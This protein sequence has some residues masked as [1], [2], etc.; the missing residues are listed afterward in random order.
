METTVIRPLLIRFLRFRVWLFEALRPGELQVTLIWAGVIGFL[1]AI[2]SVFFRHCLSGVQ[3][4]LIHHSNDLVQVSMNLSWWERLLLPT[5]GGVLAGF[6]LQLGTRLFP[7]QS[8][9][10]YMEAITLGDGIIRFRSTVIKSISSLFTIAS[11]GSIGREGPMVQLSSMIASLIGRKGKLTKPRLRLLVA[12]GAAAGIASAYNAPIAGALFVAEIIMG[13]I[14]MESFGPLIFSSVIATVTVRHILGGKP[15]YQIPPFELVSNWELIPYAFLGIITG[16]MAPGFLWLLQRS[17]TI[18]SRWIV[19][20]PFKLGLGGAIVGLISTVQPEVYGNGYS[21]VDSILHESWP[22]TLLILLLAAKVLATSVTAGSGAAGGV[23][24]PTLFVGAAIGF[25]WGVP[26]HHFWPSVM[27]SPNAYALVGMGCFL[28]GTTHA[29]LM[30]ILMIFEMTLDYAIVPPL[31]LA[32]VTAFYTSQSLRSGSIYAESLARKKEETP[33]SLPEKTVGELMK[34]EPPYVRDIARFWE[35]AQ[36]LAQYRYNYIYVVDEKD[37]FCGAISLHD[38]KE[39]LN[40][41]ELAHLII[42]LDLMRF[43]FPTLTPEMSLHEA[44]DCFLKHDGERLPVLNGDGHLLG[45]ISKTDLLLS[46][47]H[48]RSAAAASTSQATI[49]S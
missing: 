28:A 5:V 47:A 38:I 46:L 14:A 25:L 9:T 39:H 12:C 1:G 19:S 49:P 36:V 45:T 33:E 29:P 40:H 43:D 35:I 17:E 26:V 15:V 4:L 6:V 20:L 21:V 24:T 32:C 44:L 3:W 8:S 7:G 2:I 48:V 13:S 22:W 30:S 42:A 10:D 11:G 27:A 16:I 37:R 34:P 23:F 18:F 41:P 31:M